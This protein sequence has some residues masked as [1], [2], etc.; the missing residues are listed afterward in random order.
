MKLRHSLSPLLLSFVCC[1]T[2]PTPEP[3]KGAPSTGA[4]VPAGIVVAPQGVAPEPPPGLRL[5]AAFK[6]LAQR[7]ELTL[8]PSADAFEGTTE[9]EIELPTATD[10]L[11]LNAKELVVKKAVARLGG[12]ESVAQTF[13]S[14]ERV[15]L[16][17]AH[18]LG[19]GQATLHLEFTGVISKTDDSGVFHQVEGGDWYAITQFEETD[20]R[21]AFPCVDEPSAKIPWE[22][23]LRVPK[24][25]VAV[26]NTP[27]ASTEAAGEGMKRVRFA[28]T[29]P[30]PSYLV[31]FAVGPFDSV[32][33]RPAGVNKTPMRIYVPKGR[34]A[35]AAYA[36]RT[37]PEILET[38]EAYF[39]IPYPYEKLDLLAIPLTVHFGAM[40]NAGLVTVASGRLLAR[41]ENE[42]VRFQQIW[43]IYAAHEFAHQWFGDLVTLA[44]WNDIW[45]NEAFATWM[46]NKIVLAW[47]PKWG[48]DVRQ[49]EDRSVAANAD[50]LVTARSIRQPIETYDDIN[51]AF[52][53]ITYEKGAAVIRMFEMYLGKEK[54]QA[55]VQNYLRAH[56]NGNATASDFLAAISEATG[57]N[58][59]PAFDT[60]LDQSGVPEVTVQLSCGGKRPPSLQLSQQ[61]LLPVGT[62]ATADRLW[63][64]PVCARWSSAKKEHQACVLLGSATAVLPLDGAGCPEWVLPN[65][66]YAGYYRL[67]LKGTLLKTLVSRGQQALTTPETVGLLGDVDALVT[68]GRFPAGDGM[69]LSTHFTSAGERRVVEEAMALA[70]V[71]FDFLQGPAAKTYPAW[72]RD[73]FGHR[74]RTLG[75]E[76]RA[77]D[78][79]N[80]RLLRSR[81]VAFDAIRGE[82]A[83]LISAARATTARWLKDPTSVDPDTVNSA[84]SIAGAFGDASLHDTLVTRLKASADR[85][86][87]THLLVGLGAFRDP[88]LVKANLALLEDP[89]VDSRELLFPFLFL[90]LEYPG[91]AELIFQFVV[92]HFDKLASYLGGRSVGTLFAVGTH[93]CDAQH[94][95]QVEAAFGPRADK[96]LGGKREL[97]QTLEA[98]ELCTAVRAVQVPSVSHYLAHAPH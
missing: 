87:R 13:L 10:V 95:T 32:D 85:A 52:D 35:E 12:T 79:E 58:V 98:I 26:S 82:D 20:A 57:Q 6:P 2:S 91:S 68:A 1:A 62:T 65:A 69:E 75:M 84:L 7:V 90:P 47:A 76:A 72:V 60:F 53:D 81:L 64:V 93:F 30:L 19:P 37:S 45:L 24:D 78:D 17:F 15:A 28:R 27:L 71:R 94:R 14:P 25:L 34:A 22:I 66:G 36:A 83:P 74:A 40:E 43:A 88:A 80:T 77:S 92:A 55:G 63:Q 51:N 29:K 49:V 41:K 56:A 38:L 61:R 5:P 59:A 33:A 21:R 73:H 67:N 42:T 18:P 16:R 50:T 46:E 8:V 44:W 70:L 48:F 89:P 86:T 9:V 39:G 3:A 96:T 4:A 11:W 54:F 97:A 23:S 31:A